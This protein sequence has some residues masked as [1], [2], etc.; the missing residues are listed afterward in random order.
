MQVEAQ[1]K[2]IRYRITLDE[3]EAKILLGLTQNAHSA[4]EDTASAK[5]RRELW[6]KLNAQVGYGGYSNHLTQE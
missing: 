1:K 3:A 2:E 5:F 6:E 4:T